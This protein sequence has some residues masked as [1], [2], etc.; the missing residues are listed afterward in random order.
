M[1]IGE[2]VCEREE[3]VWQYVSWSLDI[4]WRILLRVADHKMHLIWVNKK[5]ILKSERQC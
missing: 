4:G 2:T 1:S 5:M 3:N